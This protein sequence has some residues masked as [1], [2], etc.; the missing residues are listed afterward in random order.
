MSEEVYLNPFSQ[1]VTRALREKERFHISVWN[2]EI[3]KWNSH[4]GIS[5]Y[6][7]E[8]IKIY[9]SREVQSRRELVCQSISIQSLQKT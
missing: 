7:Q 4:A 5:H 9:L 3:L 1:G 6:L 2:K 8:S